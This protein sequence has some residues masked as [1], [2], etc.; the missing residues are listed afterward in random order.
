MLE[1]SNSGGI[2]ADQVET[3]CTECYYVTKAGRIVSSCPLC[4]GVIVRVPKGAGQETAKSLK[5]RGT[6]PLAII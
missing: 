6:S 4:G 2:P 3:V 1:N 5:E